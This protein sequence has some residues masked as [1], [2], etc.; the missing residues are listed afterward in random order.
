MADK[1]QAFQKCVRVARPIEEPELPLFAEPTEAPISESEMAEL[2]KITMPSPKPAPPYALKPSL[3]QTLKDTRYKNFIIDLSVERD[4]KP[5][6]LTGM[7]IVA[8]TMTV[9]KATGSFDYILNN[10]SNDPTPA[11]KGIKEDQFEITEIYITN[12]AQPGKEAIIRVSY[13]PLLIRTG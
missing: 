4:R 13:T 6:G 5:I 11:E 1:R 10:P 2:Q 7:G 12:P 3:V 9:V 8:N